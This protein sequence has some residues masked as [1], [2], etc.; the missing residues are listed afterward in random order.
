M[1]ISARSVRR[2]FLIL[3]TLLFLT[4]GLHAQSDRKMDSI[5]N[6]VRIDS[7]LG[8]KVDGSLRF[9]D[10]EGKSVRLGDYLGNGKPVVLN[11][12][13]YGCP[14]L[15]GQILQGTNRSLKKVDLKIGSDYDIVT[16]S[17]DHTEEFEIA[18]RKK[19]TYVRAMHRDGAE[20]GWHFLTSDSASVAKLAE[21]VGY[22]YHR[23]E[24]TG[25]F[26]HSAAIMVLTP[27]G[28]LSRYFFGI[29]YDPRDLKLGIMDA[30]DEKIGSLGDQLM[31]LCF[32][33]D[34]TTGRYGFAITRA[35]QIV[36]ILTV[37]LLAGFIIRSIR[38]DKRAAE[39]TWTA[40]LSNGVEV[41]HGR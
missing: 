3:P 1:T 30:A 13:Y 34:P 31:L 28:V 11:L 27:E 4:I 16:I 19:T 9:T 18:A 24:K 37:L 17:F 23:D 5:V 36:G 40:P 6:D 21:Q 33:Y 20:A 25:Q 35:I 15:C 32:Q 38:R 29:E 7:K 2:S 26:A 41:H 10:S 22:K 8:E 12:V 14:M 39:A